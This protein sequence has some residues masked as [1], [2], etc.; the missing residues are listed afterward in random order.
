MYIWKVISG[1]IPN[2]GL[3]WTENSRRGKMVTIKSYKTYTPTI[4]KNM[5]DQSL[6][7]HGGRL[8]NLLP[9]KLRSY[10]GTIEGFKSQLDEFLMNIPDQPMCSD[11]YPEPVSK[12]TCRNSNSLLDWIPHLHI[13][14][15]RTNCQ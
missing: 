9:E 12:D 4:A 3:K 8:F 1:K 2:F 11:L 10:M 14:E 13:R 6:A 5:I 15:R 7:V